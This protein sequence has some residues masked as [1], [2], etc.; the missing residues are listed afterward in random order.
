MHLLYIAVIK[1][2]DYIRESGLSGSCRKEP[3][4]EGLT[5]TFFFFRFLQDK[6]LRGRIQPEIFHPVPLLCG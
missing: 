5:M 1:I 3:R 6:Q 2:S 4:T